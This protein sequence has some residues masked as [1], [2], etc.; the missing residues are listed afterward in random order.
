M[1]SP[2]RFSER[3]EFSRHDRNPHCLCYTVRAGP[4][5]PNGGWPQTLQSPPTSRVGRKLLSRDLKISSR[6]LDRHWWMHTW[7][8][9]PS[10][11][12]ADSA[13]NNFAWIWRSLM[14]QPLETVLLLQPARW[15]LTGY[16]IEDHCTLWRTFQAGIEVIDH[17][18][19]TQQI[20]REHQN[21]CK[22]KIS[23]QLVQSFI[24]P[25][26]HVSYCKIQAQST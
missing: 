21:D 12:H 1:R 26:K 25:L 5:A 19:S 10:R 22:P 8:G 15:E 6:V 9:R 3:V 20:L 11:L 23:P 24:F 17:Q 7:E 2:S 18:N 16:S 13:R 14:H 4:P